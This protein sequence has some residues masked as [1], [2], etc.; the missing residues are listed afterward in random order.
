MRLTYMSF[1][2]ILDFQA[3]L[4]SFNVPINGPTNVG[5]PDGTATQ[6]EFA[7][8]LPSTQKGDKSVLFIASGT[9][10]GG[11]EYPD[12]EFY[13]AGGIKTDAGGGTLFEGGALPVTW[14]YTPQSD[15]TKA[16]CLETTLIWI[17]A[18]FAYNGSFQVRTVDG[19]V[20]TSSFGQGWT[21]TGIVVPIP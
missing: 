5:G 2:K 18:G 11:S 7:G 17:H 14:H 15:L 13:P 3:L 21:D 12:D 9:N 16:Q 1:S 8:F 19:H 4:N 20:M 6:P 10:N